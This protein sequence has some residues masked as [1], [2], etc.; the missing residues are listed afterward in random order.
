VITHH[1]AQ[2]GAVRLHYVEAGEGPLVVLI[3]GF[4]E[5]WYTWRRLIPVLAR[6]GFRVVAVDLRGC[7]LSSKPAAVRAYG[8]RALVEDIA[9]LIRS[10]GA[11]RASVIGHDWGAGVAWALAMQH[12]ELITRLAVLNGPHPQRLI[13]AMRSPAQ[14]A[15]SWYVFFFQLPWLPEAIAGRDDFAFLL[16]PLRDEPLRP[17]A[18]DSADL[19]RYVEA[20]RQPGAV[21]A[22]FNYY[23]AMFLPGTS[24]DMRP[25]EAPALVLWGERDIHLGRELAQPDRALVPR[26]SV[27]YLPDATH[28]VQHDCPERVHELLLEFLRMV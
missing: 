7:N 4:P 18:Y 25:I 23:R 17:G 5:F 3:H 9:G 27:V 1:F 19:A 22:M 12:P 10:L 16:K 15:K 21:H 2:L 28:W 24:V 13:T 14:L 6:A 11:E 8:I 20:L 26:A